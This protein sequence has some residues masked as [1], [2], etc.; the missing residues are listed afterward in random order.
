MLE[1]GL[2]PEPTAAQEAI[3][4]NTVITDDSPGLLLQDFQRLVDL[5]SEEPPQLTASHLLSLKLLNPLNQRLARR[6]EHELARPMQKSFPHI[7]GLF[8][9]LRASGLTQVD[10]SGRKPVLIIDPEVID[11]WRALNP[12]ERYCMLLES[13]LMRGD[14]AIIG[15]REVPFA[16]QSPLHRWFEFF[17]WLPRY[18][19]KEEAWSEQ[20]RYRPGA[21]NLALMEL[22]G[23][24]TVEDGTPLPKQG[25]QITDVHTTEWGV[26]LLARLASRLLN[27]D[28]FWSKLA[29]PYAIPPGVLLPLLQPDRPTL[30]HPLTLPYTGFQDGLFVFKVALDTKI[31]REIIIPAQN[32]LDQLSSAILTA[33]KFDHDHLYR[34]LYPTRFGLTAEVTAYEIAEFLGEGGP[35]TDEVRIGDLPAQPGFRMAY[36]YDFGDDWYFDVSL[37]RIDPPDPTI[38]RSRMG[39]KMGKAPEQY[40]L[41]NW[42]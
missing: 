13:W 38:T 14:S 42:E 31:W 19:E 8:L 22:F 23:L 24:V 2:T 16:F 20:I 3:L 36:N 29:T 1:T 32:T 39:K 5:F 6:I 11:S 17:H 15:E 37:E 30:Q 35:T 18:K 28:I 7:N 25:W 27:D 40:D 33:Y 26:A 21:H 34:F 10:E 9:L 41:S 12:D 4:Q